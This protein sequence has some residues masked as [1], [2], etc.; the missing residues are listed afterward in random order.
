MLVLMALPARAEVIMSVDG[1]FDSAAPYSYVGG[2]FN[3]VWSAGWTQSTTWKNVSVLAPVESGDIRPMMIAYLTSRLGALATIAD[4][5]ASYQ[6]VP[7]PAP[8]SGPVNPTILFSGLV[9]APGSYYLT[10]ASVGDPTPDGGWARILQGTETDTLAP[11]VT[12]TGQS[13]GTFADMFQPASDFSASSSTRY[14]T[15]TGDAAPDLAVPEPG[16][17]GLALLGLAAFGVLRR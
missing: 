8:A 4:L 2:P 10:L 14:F 15:V 12:L 16:T 17:A 11:G 5:V 9:L 13:I 1:T 3:Y 7:P 6:F